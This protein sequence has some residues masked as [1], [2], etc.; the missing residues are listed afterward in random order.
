M[1]V[2][3]AH[4]AL[5]FAYFA[6]ARILFRVSQCT[7]HRLQFLFLFLSVFA[8][9]SPQNLETIQ[10]CWTEAGV[11]TVLYSLIL[12]TSLFSR[13][14][15]TAVLFNCADSAV[16]VYRSWAISDPAFSLLFRSFLPCFLASNCTCHFPTYRTVLWISVQEFV[17]NPICSFQVVCIHSDLQKI[18][19][20]PIYF[21]SFSFPFCVH[22]S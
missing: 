12:H 10:F 18:F 13:T 2:S 22:Q 19:S 7:A 1:P 4:V 5:S 21:V 9:I 17:F 3:T 16:Q 20:V 11:I 15:C 14:P 8:Q 6:S